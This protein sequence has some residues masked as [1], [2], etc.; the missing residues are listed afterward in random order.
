MTL[1]WPLIVIAGLALA[2]MI[3]ILATTR[4]RR[5][6][7]VDPEPDAET[8]LYASRDLTERYRRSEGR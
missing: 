1:D 8:T 2:L 6:A 5:A 4:R 7:H 3:A